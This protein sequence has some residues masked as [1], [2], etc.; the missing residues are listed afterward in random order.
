DWRQSSG[1]SFGPDGKQN[2]AALLLALLPDSSVHAARRA[3]RAPG[4]S[5]SSLPK[6]NGGHRRERDAWGGLE[7]AR[8]HGHAAAAGF[9]DSAAPAAKSMGCAAR[10]FHL[11]DVS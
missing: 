11:G 5:A 3:E 4:Q 7:G 2:A 1:P 9:A 8:A 6:R 10:G